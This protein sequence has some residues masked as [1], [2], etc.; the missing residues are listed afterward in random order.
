[1]TQ[2]NFDLANSNGAT[3]R[4]NVN[5]ALQALAT[6]SSG[7]SAPTTT[8]PYM[9]WRNSSTG[10]LYQRNAA[11][12]AWVEADD[13]SLTNYL[14]SWSGALLQTL[15]QKLD[16][17]PINLHDSGARGNGVDITTEL[18]AGVNAAIAAR[19]VLE[20]PP[21]SPGNY[22]KTTSAIPV[23]GPVEIRGSGPY[24]TTIL[25]EGA[26]AGEF[27]FDCDVLAAS[28]VEHVKFSNLTLR[29][30]NANPS[31]IRFNNISYVILENMRFYHLEHGAVVDGTRCFSHTWNETTGYD[32]A[33]STFYMESTY[34]G[35]GQFTFNGCTFAGDIGVSQLSGARSDGFVFNG[36]NWEQCTTHS[37]GIFGSIRGLKVS[38]GRTEG[39]DGVDF[40]IR[41]AASGEAVLGLHISGVE[42]GTNDNSAAGRIYLGGD[43]GIVRGFTIA[44]NV[45]SHVSG[46]YTGN[47]VHLNGEGESG[48]IAGNVVQGASAGVVNTT[49]AGVTVFSNENLSGKLPEYWGNESWDVESGTFA[50]VD[51]SGA[52]L[53]F[54][55]GGGHYT[56][57]GRH[58]HWQAVVLYPAT[59]DTSAAIL[60]GL[61]YNVLA[62]SA[63][64]GRAGGSAFSDSGIPLAFMQGLASATSF[65][66]VNQVS[67]ATITNA[68]L[69]S[70]TIYLSGQYAV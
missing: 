46:G 70:R 6:Q 7:G 17:L 58:V 66:F 64:Q 43:I 42:F 27:V 12:S 16:T 8:Y 47:L 9:W 3:F 50:I 15:K 5:T 49:R 69:S 30:D 48:L 33:G 40:N 67:L 52:A 44:A 32:L 68:N 20:I 13:A 34:N 51:G 10:V 57:I 25:L 56:K 65:S 41:P 24:G 61:P 19:G 35:G 59:A 14:A 28:N 55:V 37:M 53:S 45:A 11:N 21:A 63:Q 2:S 18:T 38:G 22:Y 4:G 29:S 36:C 54:S 62:G 23:D 1:M 39:C 60:G 31:G 26:S